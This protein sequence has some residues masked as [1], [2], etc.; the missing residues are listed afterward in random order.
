MSETAERL[1]IAL[2]GRYR[3]ERELGQGGM[4]TMEVVLDE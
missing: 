3:S 1:R 4:A 2:N